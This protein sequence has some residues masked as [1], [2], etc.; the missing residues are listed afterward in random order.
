MSKDVEIHVNE[1]LDDPKHTGPA[2]HGE[3][4]GI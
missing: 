1:N 2:Y 4:L 3:T